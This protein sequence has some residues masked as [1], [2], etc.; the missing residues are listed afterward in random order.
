MGKRVLVADDSA[1]IQRAFSMVFGGLQDSIS[2]VAARSFD[3]ALSLARQG[4]PDLVIADIALGNRTGYELCAALKADPG[5][6][7]IP[8]LILGS[9]QTPYDEGKGR[10]AGADGHVIETVR[11]P[12]AHRPRARGAGAARRAGRAAIRG[13]CPASRGFGPSGRRTSRHRRD[14]AGR[15][16]RRV[17]DRAIVERLRR[18]CA[19]WQPGAGV[20]VAAPADVRAAPVAAPVPRPAPAAPLPS[21]TICPGS[22]VAPPSAAVGS[23][24]ALRPSL[25]PGARPTPVVRPPVTLH[26][27][28]GVAS[29]SVAAPSGAAQRPAPSLAQTGRSRLRSRPR[30]APAPTA[31]AAMG[32]TIM[33]L[34]AVA[35]PGPPAPR[36]V[37]PVAPV[38][39]PAVSPAAAPTV[40][41]API[42]A[43]TPFAPSRPSASPAPFP[44]APVSS[45]ESAA[46]VSA[47]I[48]Q[49]VAAIASRGPEY[50]AIAKLSREVIEQVVWEVVPELAE[51][52]IR[53]HVERLANARK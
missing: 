5:L 51:L 43:I 15:R 49:K 19:V 35:I 45:A 22:F 36:E 38:V 20:R 34:P 10:Q 33:G 17:H 40:V 30:S 53:E 41:P 12:G 4:Q 9:G 18:P 23:G 42:P 25:I 52:I 32:R 50:E 2:L 26:P 14:R 3:E 37:R 47:R 7:G 21:F 6:R 13:A 28:S 27:G 29:A 44:L 39:V 31:P 1:T 46:V 24:A 11:E 8:V 16:I 48:D